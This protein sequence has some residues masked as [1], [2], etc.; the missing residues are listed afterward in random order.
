M[1]LKKLRAQRKAKGMSQSELARAAG[2]SQ[3]ALSRHERGIKGAKV[4]TVR[5]YARALG[6][7][8]RWHELVGR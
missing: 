2:V 4:D 8:S 5:A 3:P 1:N 7:A 6:M